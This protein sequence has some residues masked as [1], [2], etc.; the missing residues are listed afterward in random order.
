[1][2]NREIVFSKSF[3]YALDHDAY[4]KNPSYR[5]LLVSLQSSQRF[6]RPKNGGT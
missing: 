4:I 2:L 5:A 1:M 3:E 6:F